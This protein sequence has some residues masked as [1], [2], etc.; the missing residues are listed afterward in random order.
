MSTRVGHNY[1]DSLLCGGAP[2]DGNNG[3]CTYNPSTKRC[4]SHRVGS[5]WKRAFCES[6]ICK[7]ASYTGKNKAPNRNSHI[8]SIT[9]STS[10]YVGKTSTLYGGDATLPQY[11]AWH[12]LDDVA[13]PLAEWAENGDWAWGAKDGVYRRDSTSIFDTGSWTVINEKRDGSV[14]RVLDEPI[15]L[16]TN[17]SGGLAVMSTATATVT[18]K[19]PAALW[20]TVNFGHS[21]ATLSKRADWS[22]INFQY[23]S[24]DGSRNAD[25]QRDQFF[26]NY[27]NAL[28]ALANDQTKGAC[29]ATL[30]DA[31]FWGAVKVSTGT[32]GSADLGQLR[33]L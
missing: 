26:A 22:S 33:V 16:S 1:C 4:S 21:N 23:W 5:A 13:S 9:G 3:Y 28:R 14:T 29:W 20:F 8:I 10:T 31:A 15:V 11:E 27:V 19:E 6:C 7:G 32:D 17:R 2:Y 25:P 30:D 24:E 12:S 18:D